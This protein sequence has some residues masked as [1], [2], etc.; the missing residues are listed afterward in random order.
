MKDSDRIEIEKTAYMATLV[1]DPRAVDPSLDRL[2]FITARGE[3]VQITDVDREEIRKV[4]QELEDHLIHK[5]KVGS[6]TKEGLHQKL[7]KR[8]SRE[9]KDT[10]KILHRQLAAALIL[11]FFIAAILFIALSSF[12]QNLQLVSAIPAFLA[13]QYVGLL[14]FFWSGRKALVTALR[15]SLSSTLAALV[16]LVIGG[17]TFVTLAF[18]PDVAQ[19]PIFLYSGPLPVY[20]LGFYLLYLGAYMYFKQVSAASSIWAHPKI[21]TVVALLV[22]FAIWFIPHSSRVSYEVIFDSAI[23]SFGTG[24]LLCA[25]ASV[26]MFSAA[27]QVTQ[28]YMVGLRYMAIA[29]AIIAVSCVGIALTAFLAG[30]APVGSTAIFPIYIVGGTGFSI[31]FV[32]L[33]ISAYTL[34]LRL[35]D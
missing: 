32:L 18:L 12:G 8:F 2:R 16:I 9:Y 29:F 3:G 1:S 30:T 7:I 13:S 20:I 33:Y 14:W 15:K 19:Q 4:Q 10:A 25:A 26:L 27:R 23:A 24:A 21:M 5:E 6:F 34:K 17:V 11:P 28:R 22:Y 31:A 35:I